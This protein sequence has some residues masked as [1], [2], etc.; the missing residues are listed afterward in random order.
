M[1][2]HPRVVPLASYDFC[3]VLYKHYCRARAFSEHMWGLFPSWEI[4]LFTGLKVE[5]TLASNGEHLCEMV[6]HAPQ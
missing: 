5:F 3:A 1:M 2:V 6:N 4:L